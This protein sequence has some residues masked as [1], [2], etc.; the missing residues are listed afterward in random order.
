MRDI[1]QE[2]PEGRRCGDIPQE[3]APE[4]R[5]CEVTPPRH[6]MEIV[7]EEHEGGYADASDFTWKVCTSCFEN[8]LPRLVRLDGERGRFFSRKLHHALVNLVTVEGN[9]REAA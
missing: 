1:P 7:E 6:E 8:A 2:A 3:E 4:R 5:R 9:D